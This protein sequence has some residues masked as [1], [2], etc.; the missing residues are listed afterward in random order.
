[1]TTYHHLTES[2]RVKVKQT[3]YRRVAE[4]QLKEAE[5]WVTKCIRPYELDIRINAISDI[6][7]VAAQQG[8]VL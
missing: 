2:A 8:Y 6:I 1:M 5:S 7:R 3:K 4:Y